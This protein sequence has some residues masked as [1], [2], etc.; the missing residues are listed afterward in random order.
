M[1]DPKI[2]VAQQVP[3]T[4]EEIEAAK[5]AAVATMREL[6]AKFNSKG[7]PVIG[8]T[9]SGV[10]PCLADVLLA[11]AKW[12]DVF[13]GVCVGFAFEES[14][15]D[16]VIRAELS[17]SPNCRAPIARDVVCTVSFLVPPPV[18]PVVNGC[19]PNSLVIQCQEADC[20]T[21]RTYTLAT[22]VPRGYARAF[23]RDTP[24]AIFTQTF[25]FEGNMDISDPITI[26]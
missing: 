15:Q 3:K 13:L 5:V 25:V 10:S 23:N 22:M 17:T 4:P 16:V 11:S 12:G 14:C 24:P 18:D 21:C 26:A 7:V 20:V 19:T 1:P 2:V 6:A 9:T 8:C